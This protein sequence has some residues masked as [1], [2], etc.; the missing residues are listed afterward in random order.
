[1]IEKQL[2]PGSC[3]LRWGRF[4]Q[5]GMIYLVTV[6][7]HDR[8]RIFDQLACARIVVQAIRSNHHRGLVESACFVVMPD[9]VHWLFAL[10]ET[11]S[12]PDVMRDFKGYTAR[13]INR[14]R[15]DRTGSVWQPGFHDHAL[16]EHEDARKV[17]RY[18]IQNPIRAGLVEQLRDY[19]HWDAWWFRPERNVPMEAALMGL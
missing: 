8:R 17:S 3:A 5:P 11:K 6:V 14:L 12:L 16:R 1:M 13:M 18:V 7:T 10:G 15:F 2:H 4:S 9:H 19:P